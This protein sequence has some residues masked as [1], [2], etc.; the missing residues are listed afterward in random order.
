MK[1]AGTAVTL[2][3]LVVA[4]AGLFLDNGSSGS[5]QYFE[6]FSGFDPGAP[7][8]AYRHSTLAID[9]QNRNDLAMEQTN[10]DHGPSCSAP[11]DS[12][13]IN[14]DEAHVYYCRNHWM[15]AVGD[16]GYGVIYATASHLVDLSGNATVSWRQD[17][18]RGSSRSWVDLWIT[19]VDNYLA[20]PLEHWQ[21][22]D[23]QGAPRNAVH[24]VQETHQNGTTFDATVYRDFNPG[25]LDESW[26]DGLEDEP[27]YEPS[28][29]RRDLIE[30]QLSRTHIKVW[31]PEYDITWVDQDISP[32]L[33][34]TQGFVQWGHHEYTPQKACKSMLGGPCAEDTVHWDDFSINPSKP[35]QII[36][37]DKRSGTVF[38][39]DQPAPKNAWLRFSAHGDPTLSFNGGPAQTAHKQESSTPHGGHAASFWHPVPQGATSVQING[40]RVKDVYVFGMDGAGSGVIPTPA[41]TTGGPGPVP[42]S[43]PAPQPTPPGSTPI[44]PPQPTLTPTPGPSPQP[45]GQTVRWGDSD[46]DGDVDAVDAL[47]GLRNL[48]ALSVSQDEPCF[49][50][51]AS[52]FVSG[53]DGSALKWDDIDCNGSL[54]AVDAAK[55][56]R[57]LASLS[58]AQVQPCPEIGQ[59]LLLIPPAAAAISGTGSSYQETIAEYSCDFGPP[60][61]RRALT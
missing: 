8:D 53:G 1:R 16:A 12:H 58:V 30:V 41:P 57:H 4:A 35:F 52:V 48:A 28:A 45:S 10:G 50:L 55:K 6:S 54:S 47:V 49:E 38:N 2:A 31:M 36:R 29:T 20:L 42:T 13:P 32:P 60:Y 59:P 40:E 26:A 33:D 24:V 21:T 51:G 17:F 9:L 61:K 25:S 7:Q 15:T 27:G 44:S 56:L 37:S 43:T 5:S 11:P 39:F 14:T 18:Q 3:A 22:V 46:C 19:P 34:W 23:L